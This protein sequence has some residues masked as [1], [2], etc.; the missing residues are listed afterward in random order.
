MVDND[1]VA[2]IAM[3]IRATRL[4]KKLT[5]QQLANRT[6]VSKGLLSK[7]ENMRTVPSLPVFVTLIQSLDVSLRDFFK[8]LVLTD[9]KG[10]QLIRR[11][12]YLSKPDKRNGT[13]R[14][15]I[16]WQNISDS[17]MEAAIV[18]IEGGK[19]GIFSTG[20]GYVFLYVISGSC[21]CEICD[22]AITLNEG[23][24]MCLERSVDRSFKS[25]VSTTILQFTFATSK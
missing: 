5:I 13:R 11:E 16:L 4:E 8:D 7:I 14:H 23:D 2:R 24:A 25:E 20:S 18:S 3:K 10:Y 21:L 12:Q 1:V 19:S 17:T 22:D 6:R 15:H 9:G